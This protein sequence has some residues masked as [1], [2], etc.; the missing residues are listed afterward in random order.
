MTLSCS[1]VTDTSL[2]ARPVIIEL[3][4]ASLSAATV[5]LWGWGNLQCTD[6]SVKLNLNKMPLYGGV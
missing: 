4:Q 2:T 5:R 6:L 1:A 3:S